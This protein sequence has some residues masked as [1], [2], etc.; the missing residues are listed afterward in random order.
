MAKLEYNDEWKVLNPQQNLKFKFIVKKDGVQ[1]QEDA[2]WRE[3]TLHV[4]NDV[5]A[6]KGMVKT[7]L[8]NTANDFEE[9]IVDNIDFSGLPEELKKEAIEMEK[10]SRNVDGTLP[11]DGEM[12]H[13][14]NPD[15]KHY[16]WINKDG[17]GSDG[18]HATSPAR[19][20]P[21]D[22]DLFQGDGAEVD[23]HLKGYIPYIQGYKYDHGVDDT[24]IDPSEHDKELIDY[25]SLGPIFTRTMFDRNMTSE[26]G[27]VNTSYWHSLTEDMPIP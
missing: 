22:M 11:Q 12:P 16:D 2:Y 14:S 18:T 7:T 19:Y 27:G 6:V 17:E 8:T 25:Y 21:Y 15:D 20:F 9:G 3:I 26:Q 10:T 5:D 23:K 24:G 1:I 13:F 4:Y